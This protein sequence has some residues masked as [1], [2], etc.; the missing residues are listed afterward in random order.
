MVVR[1]D[2]S[3]SGHVSP[4]AGRVE[5]R[6][7]TATTSNPTSWGGAGRP[8]P[9]AHRPSSRT[10]LQP[11][12]WPSEPSCPGSRPP[13]RRRAECFSRR[14]HPLPSGCPLGLR[15]D[16]RREGGHGA[17]QP[18]PPGEPPRR[19]SA[20][21]EDKEFRRILV[22]PTASEPA[23]GRARPDSQGILIFP[24]STAPPRRLPRPRRAMSAFSPLVD[25]ESERATGRKGMVT[26]AVSVLRLRGSRQVGR[27]WPRPRERSHR[28]VVHASWQEQHDAGHPGATAAKLT[29]PPCP[30]P[31]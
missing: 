21:R 16:E 3:H 2:V 14:D 9:V 27:V 28:G 23:N 17:A 20:V 24:H 6:Q 25:P 29:S 1:L 5:P 19:G 10:H 26:S 31:A 4:V 30:R 8:R 12:Q 7:H 18:W 22:F 11:P 15:I 13:L